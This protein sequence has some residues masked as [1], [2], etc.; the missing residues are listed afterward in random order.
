[1]IDSVVVITEFSLGTS[2]P[3]IYT[4]VVSVFECLIFIVLSS[5]S[6][7]FVKCP[8]YTVLLHIQLHIFAIFLQLSIDCGTA[9]LFLLLPMVVMMF[10]YYSNVFF[11]LTFYWFKISQSN[12]FR[13]FDREIVNFHFSSY[14][15]WYFVGGLVN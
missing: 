12:K 14:W 15:K 4:P 8:V 1:M 11:L 5:R 9:F 6:R 13:C 3:F 7:V 2:V 10:V